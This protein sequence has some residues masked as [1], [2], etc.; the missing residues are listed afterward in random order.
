MLNVDCTFIREQLRKCEVIRVS[1]HTVLHHC[2]A[3][4]QSNYSHPTLEDWKLDLLP[5]DD[6]L[7]VLPVAEHDGLVHDHPLGRL[8]LVTPGDPYD[9]E[10]RAAGKTKVRLDCICRCN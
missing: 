10:V 6:L 2:A 8:C 4:I 5:A 1:L 7:G 3:K 9:V